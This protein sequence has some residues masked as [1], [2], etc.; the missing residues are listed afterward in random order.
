[1]QLHARSLVPLEITRDFGMTQDDAEALNCGVIPNVGVV[2]PT[3]GSCGENN[4]QERLRKEMARAA[5]PR[6]SA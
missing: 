5:T 6:K 1:V 4:R 2:Q 3:E